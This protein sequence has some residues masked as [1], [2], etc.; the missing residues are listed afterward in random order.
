MEMIKWIQIGNGIVENHLTWIDTLHHE[1]ERA[2]GQR[3]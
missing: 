2:N 3:R 1:L